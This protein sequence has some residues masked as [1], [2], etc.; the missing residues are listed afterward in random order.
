MEEPIPRSLC[1]DKTML[2]EG[3]TSIYC[4]NGDIYRG[5]FTYIYLYVVPLNLNIN[6]YAR[7][8]I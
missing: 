5:V 8:T 6:T 1:C 7:V 2:Q 3:Y 4:N